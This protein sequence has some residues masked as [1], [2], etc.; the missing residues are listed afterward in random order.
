MIDITSDSY[1]NFDWPFVFDNPIFYVNHGVYLPNVGQYNTYFD[2]NGRTSILSYKGSFLEGTRLTI[3]T[4][5][6]GVIIYYSSTE[7][8]NS[9][10]WGSNDGYDATPIEA[11]DGYASII[12]DRPIYGIGLLCI[13]DV[14]GYLVDD[15]V[16]SNIGYDEKTVD[17]LWKSFIKTTEI[18][19]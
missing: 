11:I 16:I 6:P 14:D 7:Y 12:I 3:T 8:E 19:T 13:I 5:A 2:A 4:N 10:W 1:W 18:T 9:G 15:L 17:L